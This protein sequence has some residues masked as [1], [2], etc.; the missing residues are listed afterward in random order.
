L[1]IDGYLE[2]FLIESVNM[3]NA[4]IQPRPSTGFSIFYSK[5]SVYYHHLK[6]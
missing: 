6:V 2:L 5:G 4:F 1:T 3:C